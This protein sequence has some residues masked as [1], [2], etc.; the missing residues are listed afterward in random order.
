MQQASLLTNDLNPICQVAANLLEIV[1]INDIQ[2]VNSTL[3][4]L[5]Q[6]HYDKIRSG[7]VRHEF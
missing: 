1:N 2:N 5:S 6:I 4:A 7:K 3:E